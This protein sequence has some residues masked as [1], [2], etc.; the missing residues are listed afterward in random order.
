MN[1]S[2]KKTTRMWAPILVALTVVATANASAEQVRL[3]LAT[4]SSV[5]RADTPE[6]VYL[7][8]GLEG[9]AFADAS[10]RTPV[11]VAVV[12]DKSGSMKG[13]KLYKAKEAAKM[14]VNRLRA[15]DIVSVIAYDHSVEVLV[16]ATKASEK[17]EI[18]QKIDRIVAG[19]N[20][21]LFA[22]VSKGIAEVRKFL[23]TRRISRVIL[24][25]DGLANV[26]PSSPYELGELGASL[27]K[28]GISV[29]TVGLGDGYNEDLMTRLSE[30]S[31][32][33][34]AFA[35]T[36]DD[37]ARIF[38]FELGDLLSVVAKDVRVKITC[39]SDVRPVRV[40]GRKASITGSTVTAR[41][42]QLYANQ[43]KFL[44]IEVQL[45]AAR[46]GSIRD[47]ADVRIEYDN[48]QNGRRETLARAAQIRYSNSM[49]DVE[50]SRNEA[51]L[52]SSI[53]LL[54][55][56]NSRLA[57]SLRDQGKADEAARVLQ[58]NVDFLEKNAA[59]HKSPK[60][61]KLA[62]DNRRDKA[63]IHAP[64]PVW[65]SRRKEM[66]SRQYQSDQQMAW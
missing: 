4:G 23:D 7:K 34:H 49:A 62:G 66:R 18:N 14:A 47:V 12:L 54:A 58:K 52:V 53:E 45:P 44:L 43:E 29:T 65:K 56:E 8:V 64:A 27:L 31:D 17:Y 46:D 60:L 63:E 9:L 50:S 1:E 35:R 5:V 24:L 15:D 61:K 32:G 59:V 30:A 42:N 51:V 48:T 16:P 39:G 3:R 19:G 10:V 40:L 41:I 28:E 37:L 25:S 57:V 55:T 6:T 22:G 11:N 26:G 20:T 2:A 36:A 13:E 33:N 38:N 21:A